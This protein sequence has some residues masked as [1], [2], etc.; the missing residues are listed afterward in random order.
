LRAGGKIYRKVEEVKE[1][2]LSRKIKKSK[3]EEK[4]FFYFFDLFNFVA[5]HSAWTTARLTGKYAW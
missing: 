2:K 1:V 5:K 3:Q 4:N